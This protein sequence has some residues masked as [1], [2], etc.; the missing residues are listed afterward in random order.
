M[1][2]LDEKKKKKKGV[3]P[4]GYKQPKFRLQKVQ[5]RMQILAYTRWCAFVY[6]AI[7]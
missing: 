1:C 3:A 5:G 6:V 2:I 7:H 4:T